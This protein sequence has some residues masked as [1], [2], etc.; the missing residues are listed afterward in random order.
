MST[1]AFI[2]SAFVAGA[3]AARVLIFFLDRWY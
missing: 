2:G 1:A 3:V